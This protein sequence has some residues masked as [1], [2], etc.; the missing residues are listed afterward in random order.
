MVLPLIGSRTS[1]SSN[2]VSFRLGTEDFCLDVMKERMDLIK[3]E[4]GSQAYN[5]RRIRRP[6]I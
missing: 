1:A 5:Q 6:V 3:C 2:D 4:N